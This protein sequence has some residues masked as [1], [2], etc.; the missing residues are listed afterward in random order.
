ME[1]YLLI[2]T[3]IT[4]IF[5]AICTYTDLKGKC[6]NICICLMFGIIGMV[7]R[8]IFE[9]SNLISLL[10]AIIPGIFLM[11]VSILSKEGIGKGDAIVIGTIGLYIGGINTIIILFNGVIVS[12]I[13]G[14]IFIAFMKKEKGYRLPFVPF[15][16]LAFIFQ[17]TNGGLV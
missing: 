9:N 15:L 16:T 10:Q 11:L 4:G 12:C 14:I 1:K 2:E 7:Y 6:I 8:C 17:V 5:L 3:I 13:T